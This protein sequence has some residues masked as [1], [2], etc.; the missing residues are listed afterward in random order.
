MS[1]V[2]VYYTP[3]KYIESKHGL[4]TDILKRNGIPLETYIKYETRG[5]FFYRTH[6]NGLCIVLSK[7]Q[8]DNYWKR[9][10]L[11]EAIKELE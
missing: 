7:E 5:V 4:L 9:R 1:D 8:Y 10:L 2:R 3:Y 6:V 11:I